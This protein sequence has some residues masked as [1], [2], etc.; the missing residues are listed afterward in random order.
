MVISTLSVTNLVTVGEDALYSAELCDQ[1][2]EE[3]S[4]EEIDDK[5]TIGTYWSAPS[6]Q[7]IVVLEKVN[8]NNYPL[9]SIQVSSPPP[10]FS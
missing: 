8:E 9:V 4:E 7:S 1:D 6:F 10:E 3:T 5:E 2:T